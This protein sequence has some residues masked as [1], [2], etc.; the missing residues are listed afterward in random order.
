MTSNQI[1]TA[2]P[3]APVEESR[4]YATCLVA[5]S[6]QPAKL[7]RACALLLA[8]YAAVLLLE[9]GQRLVYEPN[10]TLTFPWQERAAPYAPLLDVVHPEG[11]GDLIRMARLPHV[12]E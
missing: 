6:T 8:P 9:C 5:E 1:E 12:C 7:K 10:A 4:L 3:P 11:W 2:R